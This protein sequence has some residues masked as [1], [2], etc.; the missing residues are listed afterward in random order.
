MIRQYELV[1]RVK[2]Y[3]P[4]ADEDILNRAYVFSMMAHGSQKRANGDP[5][6]SHPVEVAGLLADMRLDTASIVTGLL[7]DVVEDTEYTTEDIKNIFGD[8]V[9]QLVDGVTKISQLELQSGQSKYAENFRKLVLAMSEDIRVLLVKLTDRLHNMRT[10]H[11]IKSAEKRRRIATETMEIYAPLAERIGMQQ[12]KDELQDIAFSQLHEEAR[13]SIMTRMAYLREEGN[14]GIDQIISALTDMLA[15]GG[16]HAEISG[17][18]KTAYSIWR[19][20]QRKNI[21]FERLADIMAF[22]LVVKDIGEC[23]QALGLIHSQFQLVPGRFK[24]YISVSKPNGYQSIHTSVFGP[25]RRPIEIQIR[26]EE[27]H[28]VSEIG[29]A[30]H[31]SY[32][33]SGNSERRHDGRQYRWLRGLLEI[34]ESASTPEE[35]LEH[36]KLEM[37]QD[38]VFCFT[39]KGDLISLP[40]G[41]TIIDFAYAVHSEI[42]DRCAGARVNG[43]IVPLHTSLQ[44]GDQVE[45]S[46]SS[47]QQPSKRWLRFVI[48]GKAKSR[49]R[50]YERI[51]Q[52]DEYV[53]LGRGMLQSMFKSEG[54]DF[55][56]KAIHVVSKKLNMSQSDDVYVSVGMGHHTANAIMDLAFPQRKA[57]SPITK[58]G[59]TEK[60]KIISRDQSHT[61]KDPFSIPI[62]GLIDGM[63]VHY[64]KCCHPLRGDRIVGIVQSGRG[65]TIHTISCNTLEQYQDEPERWLDVAWQNQDNHD[66]SRPSMLVG[67]IHI[68]LANETGSLG[69]ACTVIG[70]NDA[71]ITNLRL[72]NRHAD[73]FDAVVDIEVTD[74]RHLNNV[75][76]ALQATKNIS[77]VDRM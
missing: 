60:P 32:K 74:V 25:T 49:I 77:S 61:N 65:V 75:M 62:Q 37:F 22:R 55:T 71:N 21:A 4:D 12:M 59:P 28:A 14:E 50:R 8:Q 53:Q 41:A 27:M 69:N 16:L 31:W 23:Y 42:G 51:Q 72:N 48:T 7:H 1:E 66:G 18:E 2:A 17:R 56:D 52:R 76:A 30:A 20:M 33:Q 34:L 29:V 9:A 13:D 68:V 6:F 43:R 45:I 67:R 73:F 19:K 36:T 26:T 70:K 24:D 39:P 10:L 11:F 64:A 54:Y 44:N 47:A 40:H 35:F 38:Q 3:D 15:E 63:A 5:Y 58:N 57:I 46:T